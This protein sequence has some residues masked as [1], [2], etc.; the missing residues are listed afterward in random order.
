MKSSLRN[1]FRGAFCGALVGEAYGVLAEY[2]QPLSPRRTVSSSQREIVLQSQQLAQIYAASLI[3]KGDVD[4]QDLGEQLVHWRQSAPSL[5]GNVPRPGEPAIAETLLDEATTAAIS[6]LRAGI[7]WHQ[8]SGTGT[9]ARALPGLARIV[10]VALF[11]HENLAV[12]REKVYQTVVLTH[13]T[14]DAWYGALAI[15]HAIAIALRNELEPERLLP[16]TL[17]YLQDEAAPLSARLQ[18]A[19]ALLEAG[20]DLET[21]RLRLPLHQDP[22]AIIALA[23]YCFLSTPDDFSLSI[24]RA[25]RCGNPASI[26]ASLCGG[27]SGAYNG[28]TDVPVSWRLRY[29]TE[30]VALADQL[31]ATWAGAYTVLPVQEAV[32]LPMAPVA[33]PG[34]LRPRFKAT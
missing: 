31:L 16:R 9:T 8:A 10:P 33:A 21:A 27:L 12:L 34:I 11:F 23:F 25:V 26:L 6:R 22:A 32:P 30:P 14:L 24:R 5:S 1:R 28:W 13:N 7:P 2:Q 18:D 15:A 3:R 4:P 29:A 17:E 20:A 19:Q